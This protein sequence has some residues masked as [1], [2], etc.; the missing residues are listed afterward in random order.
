[1]TIKKQGGLGPLRVPLFRIIVASRT[2]R[3]HLSHPIPTNTANS[4]VLLFFGL[5]FNPWVS[6]VL[7][8]L[9]IRI[10]AG[11]AQVARKKV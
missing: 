3:F 2:F 7:Q 8:M 5:P 1:M 11:L 10:V 6:I 9:G 4:K